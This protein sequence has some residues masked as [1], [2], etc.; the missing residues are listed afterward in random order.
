MPI[1][2]IG[3]GMGRTGTSS[4]K[5]ALEQLGYGPCYH[6]EELIKNPADVRFWHE[7]DKHGDTDWA[8]LFSNYQSAVDFPAI[9]YYKDILRV[10]PD[11]KI[12]LTMRDEQ[13]WYNSAIKTILNAE[14]GFLDKLKMSIKLPFSPHMR[15]LIQVF[16]LSKKFWL[17]NVGTQYKDEAVAID[18]Y[19]QWN[20]K[21][22]QE[23][24]AANLLVYNVKE[25]WPPLCQYLEV[26]VPDTP[27][28]KTNSRQDFEAKSKKII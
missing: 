15:N 20:E 26:P 18:F 7:L 8:S 3:L 14:P 6:M 28:P 16:K 19:R 12:I 5:L 17:K 4:L 1:K 22:R 23:F 11:A 25:G 2:V 13:S 9:G 10:Y 27:F 24:P 21:I